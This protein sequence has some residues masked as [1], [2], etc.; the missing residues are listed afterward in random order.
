MII[1][2]TC[3]EWDEKRQKNEILVSHGIDTKIDMNIVMPCEPL[4]YYMQHSK[5]TF[6]TQLGEWTIDD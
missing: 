3:E 4:S 2:I 5:A 6:N 1:L